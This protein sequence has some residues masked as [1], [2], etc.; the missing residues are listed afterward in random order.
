VWLGTVPTAES[1]KNGFAHFR[2]INQNF[3]EGLRK[4]Y[5]NLKMTITSILKCA[6]QIQARLITSVSVC[7]NLEYYPVEGE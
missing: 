1:G 7:V 6:H 3:L 5:N 4:N 2:V